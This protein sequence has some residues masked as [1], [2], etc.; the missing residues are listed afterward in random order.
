M[1]VRGQPRNPLGQQPERFHRLRTFGGDVVSV[2]TAGET[3]L[4][5]HETARVNVVR[6]GETPGTSEHD[7]S[8]GIE[9]PGQI[10]RLWHQLISPV[11]APPPFQVSAAP[12][13]G[14]RAIRYRSQSVYRAAGNMLRF[15]RGDAQG[16]HTVIVNQS[17]QDRP[18]IGTGQNRNRPTVRN[19][20]S[21]F[22]SRVPPLNPRVAADAGGAS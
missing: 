13:T 10:R 18:T 8:T 17:R 16:L 20:M 12:F 5:F 14:Q 4:R 7:R 9:A 21:S 2:D 11:P 22:G 1:P 19:R 6:P 15:V 3:P